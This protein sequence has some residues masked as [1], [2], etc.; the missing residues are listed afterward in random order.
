MAIV[1]GT[2]SEYINAKRYTF[3]K[4]G[5]FLAVAFL[6]LFGLYLYNFTSLIKLSLVPAL[7]VFFVF[8]G[9]IKVIEELITA[10]Q[11]GFGRVTRGL[12]GEYYVFKTLSELPDTYSVFRGLNLHG[13]SD[14]D[15]VVTGPTGIFT[16]EVKSHRGTI[17]FD[18]EQLTLN[19]RRFSE[20]NILG[21][22]FNEAMDLH[23]F[24]K[25]QT[26]KDMFV[27]P[28]IAFSHPRA[29]MRFGMEKVRNVHV[30]NHKWLIEL[31]T[32]QNGIVDSDS[33]THALAARYP[34]LEKVSL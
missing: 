34:S 33:A 7:I 21:Q 5:F 20:K 14:I 26:G 27:H 1:Y 31:L 8:V 25:E 19:H 13:K 23:D 11:R 17:G 24:L 16:I 9:T 3:Y 30:I 15:F 10:Q 28:V 4:R 12:D 6:L 2:E 22:A 18:G 32:K 29:S